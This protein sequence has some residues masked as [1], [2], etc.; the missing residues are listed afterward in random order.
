MS[1]HASK[2]DICILGIITLKKLIQFWYNWKNLSSFQILYECFYI[3]YKRAPH[4]LGSLSFYSVV[5]FSKVMFASTKFVFE[6]CDL[7]IPVESKS[8]LNSTRTT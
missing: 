6:I 4:A 7:A 5:Q 3:T 2:N 1:V 8:M